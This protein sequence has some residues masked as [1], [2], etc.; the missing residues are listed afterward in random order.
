MGWRNLLWLDLVKLGN[1]LIDS[2]KQE[3][4][5]VKYFTSH[6]KNPADKRKR[7]NA[8]LDALKTLPMLTIITGEYLEN[9][10]ECRDCTRRWRDD[11]EKQT[12][13][14]IALAMLIDTLAKGRVDDLILVTADSDQTPTIKAV[15]S[16]KK[17]VLIA[18]PPGRTN[19]LGIQQAAGGHKLELTK[20]ILSSCLLPTAVATA[21][22]Y[23]I[24]C[25][26]EYL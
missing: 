19:Y 4:V 13:V 25:P 2:T 1:S 22:G 8:Y 26:A 18:I 7:Q 23:K 16:F 17:H 6:I 24:Q 5:A 9:W 15:R 12:D 21:S 3:L 14:H 10:V 11:K 20:T